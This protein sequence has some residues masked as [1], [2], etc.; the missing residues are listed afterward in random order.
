MADSAQADFYLIGNRKRFVE[1]PLLVVCKLAQKVLASGQTAVILV[2]SREQAEEL[3]DLLWSFEPEAYLP[4]Q[5]AG[6]D[7]DH[8]VAAL[9]VPPDRDDVP[10]RPVVINLRDE[11]VEGDF[12]RV[13]EVVPAAEDA[14]SGSRARWRAYQQRGV[15]LAS[16]DL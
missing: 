10:M 16:H 4:H 11:A 9:I 12:Q 7:D 2:R 14:R 8:E 3:D 15:T 6:D 13:L 1:Q 5:I